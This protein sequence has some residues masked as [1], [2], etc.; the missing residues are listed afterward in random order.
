MTPLRCRACGSDQH[1]GRCRLSVS[2]CPALLG[3]WGRLQE[4]GPGDPG[5]NATR[6]HQK[7]FPCDS[8]VLESKTVD[9]TGKAPP[10]CSFT[11]P[12]TK[13]AATRD[14]TAHP[15]LLPDR[16]RQI[17]EGIGSPRRGEQLSP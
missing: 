2:G 16:T 5:G 1:D 15:R 8:A 3:I 14:P 9:E 4:G 17:A 6:L 12:L 10:H 7:L 13:L 11:W